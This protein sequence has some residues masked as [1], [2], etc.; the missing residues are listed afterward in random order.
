MEILCAFTLN[1]V[2]L[3]PFLKLHYTFQIGQL[4]QK[5]HWATS[6]FKSMYSA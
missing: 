1:E 2:K 6:I 3:N 5:V 4:Q